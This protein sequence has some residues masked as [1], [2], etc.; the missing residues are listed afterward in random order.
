MLRR[1][2]EQEHGKSLTLDYVNQVV[3]QL[4]EQYFLDSPRFAAYEAEEIYVEKLLVCGGA[5]EQLGLLRQ[6]VHG[7]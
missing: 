2:F 4:E 1:D 5:S 7:D 3:E 6:I